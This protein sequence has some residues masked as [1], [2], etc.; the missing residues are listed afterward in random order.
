MNRGDLFRRAWKEL[1]REAE[2]ATHYSPT[3]KGSKGRSAQ[4]LSL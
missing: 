4:H 1:T 2:G 3:S